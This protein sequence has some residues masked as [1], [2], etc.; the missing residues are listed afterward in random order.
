MSRSSRVADE[1]APNPRLG[2]VFRPWL[3][4]AVTDLT[5]A[6]RDVVLD[7]AGVRDRLDTAQAMLCGTRAPL[8]VA[9]SG[10][11]AIRLVLDALVERCR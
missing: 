4:G 6:R 1:F 3:I 11:F 7:I 2:S 8:G 10:A 9:D 5:G